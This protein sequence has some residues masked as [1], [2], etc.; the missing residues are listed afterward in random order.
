MYKTKQLGGMMAKSY[1]STSS[2]IS[3]ALQEKGLPS[4]WLPYVMEL[5]GRESSWDANAKNPDSTAYGLFQF[6]DKTWGGVKASKTSDP[7]QQA[8]AG[9][10]YIKQRYGDPIK[11]LQYWDKYKSY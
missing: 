7:Y 3:K 6:I 8:L 11:A 2:V 5:T 4:S 10:D 9:L 1:Q